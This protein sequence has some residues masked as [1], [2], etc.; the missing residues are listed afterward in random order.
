MY[1]FNCESPTSSF[2]ANS[3]H[4]DIPPFH[5]FFRHCNMN[6]TYYGNDSQIYFAL[7]SNMP[8]QPLFCQ[9]ALPKYKCIWQQTF[10]K[11]KQK[12]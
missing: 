4:I 3:S 7:T 6:Y 8:R 1:L 10:F 9:Q 5:M 12:C 2:K 11:L